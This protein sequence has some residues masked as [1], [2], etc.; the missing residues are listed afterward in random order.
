MEQK[1]WLKLISFAGIAL[2]CIGTML[3]GWADDK[4]RDAVIEEKVNE[5][6]ANREEEES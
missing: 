1:N 5:A 3:S 4:E 6:I 2:G